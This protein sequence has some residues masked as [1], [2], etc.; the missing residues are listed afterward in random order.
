MYY[1]NARFYYRRMPITFRQFTE[2]IK[3][4]I[5]QLLLQNLLSNDHLHWV[6]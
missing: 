3:F 6:T 1:F 4:K 2:Q 5:K